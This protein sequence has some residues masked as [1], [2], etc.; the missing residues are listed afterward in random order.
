MRKKIAVGV[1]LVAVVLAAAVLVCDRMG[2][3]ELPLLVGMDREEVERLLGDKGEYVPFYGHEIL[4]C[5]YC[6]KPDYRGNQEQVV[7]YFDRNEQVIEWRVEELD[8][9]RPPWLDGALKSV[10]W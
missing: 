9:T 5:F 4:L 7:V 2:P 6:P 10:R 1:G 8:R 3:A